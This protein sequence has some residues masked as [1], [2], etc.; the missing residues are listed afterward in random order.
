M[1]SNQ[2]TADGGKKHGGKR[3]GAGRKKKEIAV[4]LRERF[5][6]MPLDFQL[7]YL[8]GI[9]PETGKKLTPE[10]VMELKLDFPT[11]MQ[12][13]RDAAPFVHPRLSS[14]AVK[15]QTV[16]HGLDLSKLSDEELIELRMLTAK[17]V[18]PMLTETEKHVKSVT[19]MVIDVK[20]G[21]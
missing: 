13:A 20:A 19:D 5:K 14:V 15:D 1:V 21:R 2:V 4:V 18:M 6:M 3:S 12:L 8:N 16:R 10:Q 11:K 7:A 9:D 17:A